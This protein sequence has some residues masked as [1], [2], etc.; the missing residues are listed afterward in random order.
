MLCDGLYGPWVCACR[1]VC[2]YVWIQGCRERPRILSRYCKETISAELFSLMR[3][4]SQSF[5]YNYKVKE[6]HKNIP[7]NLLE[8]FYSPFHILYFSY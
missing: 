2:V 3:L 1:L 7:L 5:M 6:N 8:S 4:D